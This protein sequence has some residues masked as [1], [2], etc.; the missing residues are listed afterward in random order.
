MYLCWRPMV[1]FGT[2]CV[3]TSRDQLFSWPGLYLTGILRRGP[4]LQKVNLVKKKVDSKD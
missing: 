3:S 2:I 1:K 4:L